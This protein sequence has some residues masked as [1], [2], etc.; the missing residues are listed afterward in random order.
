M[1]VDAGA[2]SGRFVGVASA[3]RFVGWC[4]VTVAEQLRSAGVHV[5]EV[6]H[7]GDPE[8]VAAAIAG[9]G[10]QVEFLRGQHEGR[11]DRG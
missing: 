2:C 5:I 1:A 4:L 6:R 11:A 9:L 7:S 8:R 10:T 3:T